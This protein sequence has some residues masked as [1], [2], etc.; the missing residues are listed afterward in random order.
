M[1]VIDVLGLQ[2]LIRVITIFFHF[3]IPGCDAP[4]IFENGKSGIDDNTFM[5]RM[6]T[7]TFKEGV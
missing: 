5:Q 2:S 7:A 3:S 6:E 1:S 4:C